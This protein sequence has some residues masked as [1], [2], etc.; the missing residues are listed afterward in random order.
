MSLFSASEDSRIR[1]VIAS[2][3]GAALAEKGNCEACITGSVARGVADRFSDIELRLLVDDLAA[4]AMYE[5][6]LRSAGAVVDP[7]SA[8]WNGMIT[9][10]SWYRGVFIEAAW[11]TWQGLVQSLEPVLSAQTSDHWALVEAWHMHHALPLRASP[12][13]QG[14]QRRLA[15]YSAALQPLLVECATAMWSQPHWYPLSPINMWPLAY[16]NVTMGLSGKLTQE[17]EPVLRL[18]FAI[19]QQWE[20]DYKWLAFE[21]ERLRLTL[22]NLHDRVNA[23][24]QA[25]APTE[26]VRRCL[27]LIADVLEL[28]PNRYDIAIQRERIAQTQQPEAYLPIVSSEQRYG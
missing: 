26:S 22:P 17:V 15:T 24:F 20:P 3:L 25:D 11:Q 27:Q 28:V 23:I 9:T 1:R 12:Q 5:Q 14:W 4:P 16:R 7:V 6:Q 18:L 8:S 21:R 2:D 13:L 10:K 19:N